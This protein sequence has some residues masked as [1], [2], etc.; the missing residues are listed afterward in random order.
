[1][2]AAYFFHFR[3]SQMEYNCALIK[4]GLACCLYSIK[5]DWRCTGHFPP[6]LAYSPPANGKHGAIPEK[7]FQTLLTNKKHQTRR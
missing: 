1:M 2:L 7:M 4:S 5:S 6:A 3:Q